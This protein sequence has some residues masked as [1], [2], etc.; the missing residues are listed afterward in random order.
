MGLFILI[1]F[2]ISNASFSPWGATSNCALAAGGIASR[3][4]Y[5]AQW[6]LKFRSAS[7]E[8]VSRGLFEASKHL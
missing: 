8:D 3:P 2:L 1:L 7:G 6:L 5:G 4:R